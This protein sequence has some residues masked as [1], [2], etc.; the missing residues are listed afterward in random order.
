[1]L[2][3]TIAGEAITVSGEQLKVG[4]KAPN[5]V[6]T[7]PTLKP[8]S[9]DSVSG[10]KIISSIPSLDTGVCQLQTKRFNKEMLQLPG[11]TLV[12]VSL[13]LPFAQSRWCGAEGLE[14]LVVISDYKTRDFATKYALLINELKLLSR[15][16]FVLDKDNII[17]CVDYSKEI[18]EEP[19]YKI[20]LETVKSLLG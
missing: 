8:W 1:M 16:V 11:V 5:F 20:V 12:T 10:I 4:D 14:D 13:D 2:N 3:L 6:G 9:L 17:R 18:G 7:L 19:D 15:A